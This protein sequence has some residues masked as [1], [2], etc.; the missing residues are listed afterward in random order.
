M[1]S[2]SPPTS[3]FFSS[4]TNGVITCT[5]ERS[6]GHW[7]VKGQSVKSFYALVSDALMRSFD[8]RMSLTQ[9]PAQPGKVWE[10]RCHQ[11]S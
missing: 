9:L 11:D 7:S 10:V 4:S 3:Q 6:A 2:N 5:W 8:Q 1:G